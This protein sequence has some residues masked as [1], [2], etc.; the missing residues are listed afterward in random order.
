MNK[1]RILGL[2]VCKAKVA[3]C[4]L[5]EVSDRPKE[6]FRRNR[7]TIPYLP[8]NGTGL[9]AAIAYQADVVI[10]EPTGLHYSILW[11][12]RLA[13]AGALIMWVGH[14]QLKYHRSDLRLPNKNDPA[15]AFALSHYGHVYLNQPEY[16]LSL[17]LDGCGAEI[18]NISLQLRHLAKMENP[19]SNRIKQN[20][21]HEWPEKAE[22]RSEADEQFAAPLWR[23]IAGLP[24]AKSTKTIYDRSLAES[25]GY[26]LTKFTIDHCQK[27]VVLQAEGIEIERHM[28]ALTSQSQF[29]RYNVVFDNFKM[30]RRV[31]AMI[32][33]H[34]YPLEQFLLANLHEHIDYVTNTNGKRSKRRRSLSAFKL[35]LGCGLVEDSSGK[36]EKWIA[37]G[38]KL[39][40]IA[41]WQWVYTIIEKKGGKNKRGK[42][43]RSPRPHNHIGMTLG[44]KYDQGRRGG[45]PIR[46]LRSR[47]ANKAVEM[48]F[49]ELLAEL[50]KP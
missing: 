11:A 22:T 37:G 49:D 6:W 8:A 40:R 9:A 50:R 18:R 19:L 2:D 5:D 4:L 27:L 10:L 42:L 13:E 15:D 44:K 46:L 35:A 47:I 38:S 12:R 16:F 43:V 3:A 23:Y 26:G 24:V 30:G 45:T 36:S 48:L 28:C 39:C 29:E 41:L 7:K 21:A 20:L 33:S 34:I 1:I 25:C 17:D 32:L 14:A 31:R